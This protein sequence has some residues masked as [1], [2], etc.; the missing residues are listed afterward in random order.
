MDNKALIIYSLLCCSAVLSLPN[1]YRTNMREN[2][3]YELSN[4]LMD[5]CREQNDPAECYETVLRLLMNYS[6]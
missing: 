3:L 6:D 4:N 2:R 1:C 5:Y